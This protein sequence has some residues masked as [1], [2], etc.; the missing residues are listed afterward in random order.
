MV[1]AS[2]DL[3]LPFPFPENLESL[4]AIGSEYENYRL[5]L[6]IEFNEGMTNIYNR[7]H[8]R[9]VSHHGIDR[10][11]KLAVEMDQAVLLAYDWRDIEMHHGF[12]ATK[13]G[14]RFTVDD[15]SRREFLR[16]LLELNQER[17]AEEVK[18]GLHEKKKSG[19]KRVASDEKKT[20]K[21]SA[22][23]NSATMSF[24]DDEEG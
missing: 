22:K 19:K 10:M 9:D 12:Y 16:R 14:I 2:S 5:R 3:V 23:K 20:R 6:M 13:Q 4:D 18:Q 11:R 15:A 21:V 7:F 24:L 1:Y 17:Y 8:D